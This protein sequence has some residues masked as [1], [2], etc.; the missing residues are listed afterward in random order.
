MKALNVRIDDELAARVETVTR[1]REM[2]LA[3]AVREALEDWVERQIAT[4]EFRAKL[5]ATVEA[6]QRLLK[7]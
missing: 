5:H 2:R 6:D 3:T 7:N 4:D 1:V